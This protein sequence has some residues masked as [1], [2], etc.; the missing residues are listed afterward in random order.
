MIQLSLVKRGQER[1]RE[2]G[3]EVLIAGLHIVLFL[4]DLCSVE[5]VE[6]TCLMADTVVHICTDT[7]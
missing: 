7:I 6:H 1:E 2:R 5:L 3:R 4:E